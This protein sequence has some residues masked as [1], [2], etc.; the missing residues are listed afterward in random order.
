MTTTVSDIVPLAPADL[1]TAIG[2]CARAFQRDPCLVFSVPDEGERLRLTAS[3][4]APVL[5]VYHRHGGVFGFVS[6][7][8]IEGVAVCLPPGEE[9]T[10][11]ELGTAGLDQALEEWGETRFAPMGSF[12]GAMHAVRMRVMPTPH[13]YCLLLAVEPAQQRQGIGGALLRYVQARAAAAR[14]PFYLETDVPENVGY[15]EGHGFSVVES[16]PV[17][18]LGGARTWGLRWEPAE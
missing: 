6:R 18:A 10:D 11:E 8:T 7:G 17:P 13:W 9:A 5:R 12:L 16:W 15:Y 4:F 3:L 14:V 1:E 2:V